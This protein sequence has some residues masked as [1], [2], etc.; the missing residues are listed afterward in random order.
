MPLQNDPSIPDEAILY[1]VLHNDRNWRTTDNDG[2]YRASSFAFYETRGEVS[3]FLDSPGVL[4][5]LHRMFPGLEIA[6]VP[7]AVLRSPEV[8][9]AI[10]RRPGEVPPDFAFDPANHV[11]AGPSVEITR[12]QFQKRAGLIAKASTIIPAEG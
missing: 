11:V 8:G 12:P 9:F 5:E 6:S 7:A 3:Y 4:P 10:E 1:R 2:R